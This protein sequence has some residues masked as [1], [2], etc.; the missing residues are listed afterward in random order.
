MVNKP[1]IRPYFLGG[2][3]LGVAR[4]PMKLFQPRDD[5]SR[6][7]GNLMV[8]S[9]WF[10]LNLFP[11][12]TVKRELN[13]SKYQQYTVTKML[14]GEIFGRHFWVVLQGPYVSRV[15]PAWRA[16]N[17]HMALPS[18]R[19]ADCLLPFVPAVPQPPPAICTGRQWRCRP[20][21]S[22]LALLCT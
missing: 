3:A 19:H 21:S 12:K 9:W 20:P 6:F 14:P 22:T 5:F 7:S 10:I 8:V 1:L 4:I 11:K 2:V 17:L 18:C 13:K 15:M 16:M